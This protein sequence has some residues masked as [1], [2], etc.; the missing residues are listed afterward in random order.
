LLDSAG[1]VMAIVGSALLPK[2]Q[3]AVIDI[4]GRGIND[5]LTIGV[6]EMNFSF[7]L[8][9]LCFSYIALYGSKVSQ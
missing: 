9:L 1:L 7:L 5:T 8:P 6:F 3:A 2:L 4:F